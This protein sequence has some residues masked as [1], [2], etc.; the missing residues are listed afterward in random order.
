MFKIYQCNADPG[1]GIE[2]FYQCQEEMA[3]KAY[4]KHPPINTD[5]PKERDARVYTRSD[6][7]GQVN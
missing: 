2:N 7:L 3:N 6:N 5:S 1:Y 4:K